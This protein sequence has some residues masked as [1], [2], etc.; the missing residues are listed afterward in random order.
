MARVNCPGRERAKLSKAAILPAN[1]DPTGK[2]SVASPS[3]TTGIVKGSVTG[4]DKDKDALTYLGPIGPTAKGGTV[5]VDATG[6]FTY[7]PSAQARHAAATADPAAKTDTFTVTVDDGHGGIV[8]VPVTVEISPTNTKPD[9]AAV[10]LGEPNADGA[11]IG[12]VTA[13]DADNDPFTI[14]GPPSTRK[15]AITYDGGNHTFTYTPTAAARIA[16]S[17]PNASTAV[18]TDTFTVT[19]DDGH[20]GTAVV[21]V[22]VTIAAIDG[23]FSAGTANATTGAITGEVTARDPDGNPLSYSGSF[24]TGNGAVTVQSSETYT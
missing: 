23:D 21:S 17:A 7:T 16:A 19:V 8:P 24:N 20:G 11:V 14:T 6:K 18:R 22:K 10:A 9:G 3:S 12:T 2:L 1:V 4:T 5:V 13:N 15:G